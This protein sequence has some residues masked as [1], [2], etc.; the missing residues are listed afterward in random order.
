[1]Q[2]GWQRSGSA[3]VAQLAVDLRLDV[4][5]RLAARAAGARCGRS[6][7]GGPPR[8]APGVL[9]GSAR[10]APARGRAPAAARPRPRRR[11]AARRGR[12]GGRG[13]PGRAGGSRPRARPG[14]RVRRAGPEAAG[15]RGA[16]VDRETA[17][18]E[19]VEQ[20]ES[21]REQHR[22]DRRDHQHDDPDHGAEIHRLSV[23]EGSGDAIRGV[24]SGRRFGRLLTRR[25]SRPGTGRRATACDLPFQRRPQQ[26]LTSPSPTSRKTCAS[27][28][29]TSPRRRSGRSPGSTTGTRPGRRRSSR[30][31]T[32]SA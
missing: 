31:R 24:A 21:A 22:R 30:R 10:P 27:W 9:V 6:R 19:L 32:R 23:A 14:E 17:P 8:A 11:A 25:I 3:Q 4:E 16:L 28:R 2:A 15:V 20:A 12:P 29:T 26:W 13:G 18:A 5:R 1:M 7:A